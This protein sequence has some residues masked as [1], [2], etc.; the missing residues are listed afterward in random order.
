MTKDQLTLTIHKYRNNEISSYQMADA[1]QE[2]TDALLKQCNVLSCKEIL[3]QMASEEYEAGKQSSSAYK[4]IMCNEK[5]DD[6]RKLPKFY[7]NNY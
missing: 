5:V 6:V 1:V 3:E 2:Y 7:N 4:E